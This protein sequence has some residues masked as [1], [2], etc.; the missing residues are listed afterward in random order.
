MF[1]NFNWFPR[2]EEEFCSILKIEEESNIFCCDEFVH[3]H[4]TIYY[5]MIMR[6]HI[7]IVTR[8][9]LKSTYKVKF[10]LKMES[11]DN[12]D[13][14]YVGGWNEHDSYRRGR[15]G[16]T[17]EEMPFAHGSYDHYLYDTNAKTS[18]DDL[19]NNDNNSTTIIL[20]EVSPTD[21]ENQQIDAS[22]MENN[23][24]KKRHRL[25]KSQ[26]VFEKDVITEE[27]VYDAYSNPAQYADYDGPQIA[28]S[29]ASSIEAKDNR[30]TDVNLHEARL[31]NR[32]MDEHRILHDP[33]GDGAYPPLCKTCSHV[34]AK[35]HSIRQQLKRFTEK[36]EMQ[37]PDIQTFDSLFAEYGLPRPSQIRDASTFRTYLSVKQFCTPHMRKMWYATLNT[38]LPEKIDESTFFFSYI[39]NQMRKHN[40]ELKC[41]YQ[42]HLC[43]KSRCITTALYQFDSTYTLFAEA[44]TFTNG[45]S[46]CG[47]TAFDPQ[48]DPNHQD[49]E[50]PSISSQ[51]EDAYGWHNDY[52]PH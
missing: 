20:S 31:L 44:I 37:R 10:N 8:S 34:E 48:N 23:G 18:T 2:I 5:K 49:P 51:D 17:S 46:S 13:S 25:S 30:T 36:S 42:K 35:R 3:I 14:E 9:H 40:F 39:F 21:N 26:V 7:Y 19:V 29:E 41:E 32:L 24:G 50:F 27:D 43:F 12:K 22:S 6:F 33:N 11:K 47:Y 1:F 28:R 45:L 4:V 15:T 38:T 16:N 52:R